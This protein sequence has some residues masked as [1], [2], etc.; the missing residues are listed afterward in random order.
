M[1]LREL[2]DDYCG[3]QDDSDASA[4][5]ASHAAAE[6]HESQEPSSDEDAP[7]ERCVDLGASLVHNI[8]CSRVWE[9]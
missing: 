4:A 9:R 6:S 1:L 3:L 5:A 2:D 8:I 7:A